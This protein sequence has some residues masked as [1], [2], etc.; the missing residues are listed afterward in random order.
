M[1]LETEGKSCV[2]TQ[3][4]RSN[5]Q[6]KGRRGFRRGLEET[7]LRSSANFSASFAVDQIFAIA[8]PVCAG[9]P[10]SHFSG[11]RVRSTKTIR[12]HPPRRRHVESITER[13]ER[14][15]KTRQQNRR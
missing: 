12:S 11:H 6:R 1:F 8:Q 7:P 13:P 9:I 2:Q 5:L 3:S 4:C 14:K 10:A 15:T